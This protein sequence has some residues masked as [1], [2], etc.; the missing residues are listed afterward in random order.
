MRSPRASAG[1]ARD[2]GRWRAAAAC[3]SP[4]R[5]TP[6]ARACG[7]RPW[8]ALRPLGLLALQRI[9]LGFRLFNPPCLGRCGAQRLLLAP[10]FHRRRIR[11][12]LDLLRRDPLGNLPLDARQ[13]PPPSQRT[14]ASRGPKLDPLDRHFRQFHR[15]FGQQRRQAL[16]QPRSSWS[17]CRRRNS[18]KRS[19]FTGAP[20]RSHRYAVWYSLSWAKARADLTPS[21]RRIEP[22]SQ[23][24][25]RIRR[26]L[27]GVPPKRFDARVKRPQ[28][29]RLDEP[30]TSPTPGAPP[31][32]GCPNRPSPN[33]AA[34]DLLRSPARHPSSYRSFQDEQVNHATIKTESLTRSEAGIQAAL[35]FRFPGMTTLKRSGITHAE[36]WS[37][38]SQ[39]RLGC[40]QNDIL[41]H[42]CDRAELNDGV[43]A[44]HSDSRCKLPLDGADE[45]VR[46]L[47]AREHDVSRNLSRA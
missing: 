7:P 27:P 47:G 11:L 36:Q 12:Q 30:P 19:W 42:G 35:G 1:R 9:E 4:S 6:A 45:A 33:A 32:I 29:Q 16:R 13:P 21:R 8:R 15:P 28:V 34:R 20:P 23:Q 5:D 25:L 46:L 3:G 22:Q 38:R 37:R 39:L 31:A 24:Y 10:P 41:P 43:L 2:C 18:L 17:P 26:G 40:R 14:Q 44:H